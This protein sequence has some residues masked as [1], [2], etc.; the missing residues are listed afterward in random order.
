MRI[1]PYM[2]GAMMGALFYRIQL[3]ND[4]TTHQ[5]SVI[6][7]N[8]SHTQWTNKAMRIIFTKNSSSR[9]L[10]LSFWTFCLLLYVLTNF[11][12]YWRTSPTWVVATIMS[13][14]KCVFSVC[15]GGVII[16]CTCGHGRWLNTFLCCTPFR[17]LSQF[18]FSIYMLAPLIVVAIF[19]LRNEPSKFTEVGSGAD[20]VAVIVTAFFSALLMVL[21]IELPIQRITTL[22]LKKNKIDC[23]CTI[24][25]NNSNN[26]NKHNQQHLDQNLTNQQH[27]NQHLE[28]NNYIKENIYN[29][30]NQHNQYAI[31]ML[32]HKNDRQDIKNSN[33]ITI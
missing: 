24:N 20:F 15:V 9:W 23:N 5:N 3:K 32:Y 6:L 4:N 10:R 1:L 14:G 21:L 30:K 22:L 28:Q 17:F 2:G 26:N 7:S 29:Q 27:L 11:M 12:S 25:K 8:E 19:G 16:M 18:C 13:V 31:P 33:N